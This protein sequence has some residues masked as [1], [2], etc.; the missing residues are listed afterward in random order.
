MRPEDRELGERPAYPAD[1]TGAGEPSPANGALLAAIEGLSYGAFCLLLRRLLH[2]SGYSSVHP[3]G[4]LFRPDGAADGPPPPGDGFDPYRFNPRHGGLDLAALSHTDLATSLTL[5][6]AKQYKGPVPR[7]FVDELRGAMH[8]LGA[9]Q[10]LLVTTSH[11]SALARDA[12]SQSH[13]RP[14]RLVDGPRLAALLST[15]GLGVTG[16][17]RRE[18]D[19]GYFEELEERAR[20][21]GWPGRGTT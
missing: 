9:D 13:L 17:D 1:T 12:A 2:R 14:V 19:A 16:P 5:V 4:R 21:L 11:F 6:Q 3:L 10:G 15:R 18:P 8:R 7:R 20:R